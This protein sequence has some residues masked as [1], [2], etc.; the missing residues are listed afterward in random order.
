[1]NDIDKAAILR[2]PPIDSLMNSGAAEGPMPEPVG[3]FVE[4]YSARGYGG[5]VHLKLSATG[6]YRTVCGLAA[7]TRVASGSARCAPCEDGAPSALAVHEWRRLKASGGVVPNRQCLC[8]CGYPTAQPNGFVR[9]HTS[10]GAA[11][12]G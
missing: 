10:R 1:M 5:V 6:T 11:R 7:G 4:V 12:R 8:G 9:G 3:E 2:K